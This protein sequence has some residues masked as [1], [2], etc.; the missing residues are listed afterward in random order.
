M[1]PQSFPGFAGYDSSSFKI[2]ALDLDVVYGHYDIHYRSTCRCSVSASLFIELKIM[3]EDKIVKL[4]TQKVNI[5][6]FW[7]YVT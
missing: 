6:R 2:V 7:L 3:G 4:K 1:F 5:N